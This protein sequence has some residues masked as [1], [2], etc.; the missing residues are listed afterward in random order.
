[1]RTIIVFDVETPN[2]NND[3]ICAIGLCA[4]QD[5]QIT[6]RHYTLVNPECRFDARNVQIHG[7]TPQDVAGAPAFPQVW[8]QIAPLLCE[9]LLAA[10]NAIF[11]LGVL[12]KTLCAYGITA[13]RVR[14]IDTLT[15]SRAMVKRAVDHRLSTLCEMFRIPLDHHNA[16]SD[17]EA[18]AQLLCLLE[19]RGAKLEHYIKQYSL[20]A[21][22]ATGAAPAKWAGTW[23]G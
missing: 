4:V 13:P 5:G 10:H 12:R 6:Q 14:Y 19:Q 18:C 21:Q 15:M 17:S 9:N 16:G 1:M 2:W 7:I 22:P 11:D 3:R 8:E 23:R 20:T